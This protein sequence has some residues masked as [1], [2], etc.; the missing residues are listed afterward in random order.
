MSQATNNT[1]V[2]R[3][4]RESVEQATA[5]RVFGTPVTQDGVTVL[6]VAR[7]SGGGGG[8]GGTGPA[9]EGREAGGA[10]GGIGLSA[11][12]L[13]AFVIK[14][15]DVSW[16]P[17]IDVN[18]VILGGQIVAVAAL[19]LAREIVK[20]ARRRSTGPLDRAARPGRSR[21]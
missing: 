18:K 21:G 11:K 5:G 19:L 15:G 1:D 4:I 13:G 2:I 7:I 14:G 20:S 6:P 12:P 17:A 8:G 16:R 9:E 10:G 3:T